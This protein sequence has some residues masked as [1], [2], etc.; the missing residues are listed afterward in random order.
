MNALRNIALSLALSI[1]SVAGASCGLDHCPMDA[2]PSAAKVRGE[3][4]LTSRLTDAPLW[5]GGYGELFLGGHVAPGKHLKLGGATPLIARSSLGERQIGIGNTILY[6]DLGRALGEGAAV[7]A[8]GLQAELPTASDEALGDRHLVVMPYARAQGWLGPADLAVQVAWGQAVGAEAHRHGIGVEVNPHD[9]QELLARAE[10]G[11]TR[12]AA[13][14][15][16]RP[17]ARVDLIKSFDE[18]GQLPVTVGP[19]V[20]LTR[21]RWA[22]NAAGAL[23]VTRDRRVGWRVGLGLT[24]RLGAPA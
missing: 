9:A 23:P 10:L 24:A 15:A 12:D 22:L 21:G 8:A 20:G 2:A 1:P 7:V 14:G 11:V 5:P 3:L 13:W 18:G 6:A 4:K 16:L 19:V 17:G